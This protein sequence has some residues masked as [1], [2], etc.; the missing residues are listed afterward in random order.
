MRFYAL[1]AL[2]IAY[3]HEYRVHFAWDIAITGNALRHPQKQ[4]ALMSV[5]RID[6]SIAC[7]IIYI[8]QSETTP[9]EWGRIWV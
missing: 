3:I 1:S 2:Y 6:L 7:A 5:S 9:C 4:E 8:K